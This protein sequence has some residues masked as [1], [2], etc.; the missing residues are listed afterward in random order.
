MYYV[1]RTKLLGFLPQTL[2][3]SPHQP[4]IHPTPP[5]RTDGH[6][7]LLCSFPPVYTYVG[8]AVPSSPS[9]RSFPSELDDKRGRGKKGEERPF[10]NP[11][12]ATACTA[13]EGGREGAWDSRSRVQ[14]RG[15]R[16]RVRSALPFGLTSSPM[17]SLA[18]IRDA[19]RFTDDSGETFWTLANRLGLGDSTSLYGLFSL[20]ANSLPISHSPSV[21]PLVSSSSPPFS[22]TFPMRDPSDERRGEEKRLRRLLPSL[23]RPG[24]GWEGDT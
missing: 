12:T 19:H 5:Q 2:P 9:G 15:G 3:P 16:R 10:P 17:T 8:A 7:S 11:G 24:G 20:L 13:W 4:T 23:H 22:L 6:L 1:H 21:F 18:G 14:Q